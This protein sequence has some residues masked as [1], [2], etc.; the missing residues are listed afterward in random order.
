MWRVNDSERRRAPWL[1]R[2][3]A[4]PAVQIALGLVAVALA[5][6]IGA[7]WGRRSR[8]PEP[9]TPAELPTLPAAHPVWDAWRAAWDG[10]VDAY[11]A[12]FTGPARERV[13]AELK[14]EGSAAYADRLRATGAA[15]LSISLGK[16]QPDDAAGGIVL[17]VTV[18]RER[19]AERIDYR[20]VRDG[21][22]WKIADAV[23]RGL[24]TATP[25]Y[26]ERLAPPAQQ[27]DTR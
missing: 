10:E 1:S 21:P 3:A 25:P 19:D 2:V 22:E 12:C 27:G 20:V 18:H 16:P 11:R 17:P 13:E 14:A 8:L 26:A 6:A 15:A 5:M 7:S 23:S 9:Q 4:H 24:T